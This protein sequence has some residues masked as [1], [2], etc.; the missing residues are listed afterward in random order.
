MYSGEQIHLQPT[1]IDVFLVDI[2]SIHSP[3]A[4]TSH[5]PPLLAYREHHFLPFSLTPGP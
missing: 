1:V 4:L 3:D 2:I 5:W